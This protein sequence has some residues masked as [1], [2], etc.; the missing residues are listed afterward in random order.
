MFRMYVRVTRCLRLLQEE[1]R[2]GLWLWKGLSQVLRSFR[3][4]S[5]PEIPERIHH[6]ICRFRVVNLAAHL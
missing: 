1:D 4:G 6:D 5:L 3:R 2:C